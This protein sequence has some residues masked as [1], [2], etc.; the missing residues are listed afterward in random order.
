MHSRCKEDENTF[1]RRNGKNDDDDMHSRCK[2]DELLFLRMSSKNDDNE[3][4]DE[5]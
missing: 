5:D 2:E 3:I 4:E 1:P